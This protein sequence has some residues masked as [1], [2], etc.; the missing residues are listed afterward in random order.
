[1]DKE[2]QA[3]I[4]EESKVH[5][6]VGEDRAIYEGAYKIGAEF[7]YK[8]GMERAALEAN[9]SYPDKNHHTKEYAQGYIDAQDEVERNIRQAAKGD[10]PFHAKKWG[11][12]TDRGEK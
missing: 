11:V 6:R 12:G 5:H 4:E 10:L 7:G 9:L 8:L 3:K 1:M 2:T